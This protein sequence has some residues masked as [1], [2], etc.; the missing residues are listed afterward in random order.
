MQEARIYPHLTQILQTISDDQYADD[1]NAGADML[2]HAIDT[3]CVMEET[4]R[5]ASMPLGKYK[6]DPPDISRTFGFDPS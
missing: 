3:F 1:L 6:F 4:T 5:K 2:P